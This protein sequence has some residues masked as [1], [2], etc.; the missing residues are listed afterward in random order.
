MIAEILTAVNLIAFL[1][2]SQLDDVGATF[3]S[4]LWQAAAVKLSLIL[5]MAL[6]R[7]RHYQKSVSG[8]FCNDKLMLT[9]WV[10]FVVATMLNFIANVINIWNRKSEDAVK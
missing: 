1:I 10:A 7:M 2:Y 6:A 8:I 3:N 9:H 4:W 5:G